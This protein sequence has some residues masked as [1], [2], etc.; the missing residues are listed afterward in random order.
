MKYSNKYDAGLMPDPVSSISTP[1]PWTNRT[2]ELPPDAAE[3]EFDER[4]REGR[5]AASHIDEVLDNPDIERDR[6]AFVMDLKRRGLSHAYIV[7]AVKRSPQF[8]WLQGHYD[9]RALTNDFLAGIE[10]EAGSGT[11]EDIRLRQIFRL[12]L[13]ISNVAPIAQVDH[14]AMR[15]YADLER[16]LASVAGTA[17]TSNQIRLKVESELNAFLDV[18][19][20]I[21]PPELWRQAIA[22]V[23][24]QARDR[25]LKLPKVNLQAKLVESDRGWEEKAQEETAGALEVDPAAT[26]LVAG[27]PVVIDLP[28]GDPIGDPTADLGGQEDPEQ[29]RRRGRFR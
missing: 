19:R 5:W 27:Y 13:M 6:I 20:A 26:D 29:I 15:S 17:Q 24:Q 1:R 8:S 9:H 18:I 14:R 2:N 3:V 7:Q 23:L 12:E 4:E 22:A 25:Q 16:Q 10:L 28:I 21:L 11:P